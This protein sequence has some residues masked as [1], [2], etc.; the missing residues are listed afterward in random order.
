MK[1]AGIV[2]IILQFI[3]LI[4]SLA[5]G[6]N[7]FSHGFANLLGRFLIGIVGVILLVIACKREKKE[8]EN[9]N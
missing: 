9:D 6:D 5:A 3:S 4:P 1:I 7:I 8:R 2:L